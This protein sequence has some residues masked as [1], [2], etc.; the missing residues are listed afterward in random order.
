MFVNGIKMS[1]NVIL[2]FIELNVHLIIFFKSAINHDNFFKEYDY[3]FYNLI[4]LFLFI[5]LIT[6]SLVFFNVLWYE[7]YFLAYLNIS[8]SPRAE[9]FVLLFLI[10]P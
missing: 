8:C 3:S 2:P 9:F 7:C 4:G 10:F 5:M 1:F 6:L